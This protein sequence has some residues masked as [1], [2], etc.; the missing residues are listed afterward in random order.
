[1]KKK[2][3]QVSVVE[4]IFNNRFHFAVLLLISS[5]VAS[6]VEYCYCFYIFIFIIFIYFKASTTTQRKEKILFT[7]LVFIRQSICEI[8]NAFSI[9]HFVLL[10]TL[11]LIYFD[12]L[13]LFF[14]CIIQELLWRKVDGGKNILCAC[15][16]L[17]VGKCKNFSSK[18]CRNFVTCKM[19]LWIVV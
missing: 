8:A 6:C 14:L 2:F 5:R 13:L 10:S 15:Y 19:T 12:W 9:R 18:L 11:T 1:M 7:H 16:C 17:S 3:L 4:Q